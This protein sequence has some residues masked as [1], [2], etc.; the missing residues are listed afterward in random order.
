MK[1]HLTTLLCAFSLLLISCSNDEPQIPTNA[2]TVNMMIGDSETTI[3][4]SDVYINTS[5]NFTTSYCGIADFGTKGS[6]NQNPNLTQIAQEVAVTPGNYYQIVN[7]KD[8]STV[9]GERAYPINTNYYNV[10]VDSPIYDKENDVCGAKVKYAEC[11]PAVSDK[12]L[13]K[14]G[15]TFALY[16]QAWNSY[17]ELATYMFQKNVEIDKNYRIYD[18]DGDTNLM[19]NLEVMIQG[20]V[21]EFSNKSFTPNSKAEVVVFVRHESLYTEVHFIITSSIN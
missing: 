5:N 11:F 14:W 18:V 6:F 3:G 16:L 21:I 1:K 4:G 17:E 8:I 12:I 13:P 19:D 9:A 15:S 7:S 2:I 20:N 10:Y